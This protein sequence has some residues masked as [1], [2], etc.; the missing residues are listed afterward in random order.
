MLVDMLRST[1]VKLAHVHFINK[2]II[3]LIFNLNAAFLSRSL[4]SFFHII[5]HSNGMALD[6]S[7]EFAISLKE[8]SICIFENL[9]NKSCGVATLASFQRT[10]S[11]AKLKCHHFTDNFQPGHTEFILLAFKIFQSWFDVSLS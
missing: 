5:L 6:L 3:E 9:T 2:T 10:Y 7:T 8:Y 1:N 4:Q 11:Y